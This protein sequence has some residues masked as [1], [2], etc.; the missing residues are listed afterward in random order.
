MFLPLFHECF[1]LPLISLILGGVTQ[2]INTEAAKSC[3][4]SVVE[5]LRDRRALCQKYSKP[6]HLSYS[7]PLSSVSYSKRSIIVAESV[8]SDRI[9]CFSVAMSTMKLA[10]LVSRRYCLPCCDSFTNVEAILR[11][12]VKLIQTISR[13]RDFLIV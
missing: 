6:L 2:K 9:F 7:K 12:K 8:I 10:G 4:P 11:R 1:Q 3:A 5:T 13:N